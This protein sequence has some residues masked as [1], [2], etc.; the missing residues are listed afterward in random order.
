MST[1][2]LSQADLEN[3]PSSDTTLVQFN[4]R[5]LVPF[6]NMRF[7]SIECIY[8][9]PEP[10]RHMRNIFALVDSAASRPDAMQRYRELERGIR[11]ARTGAIEIDWADLRI[12]EYEE[13][14]VLKNELYQRIRSRWTYMRNSWHVSCGL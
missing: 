9:V 6:E 4:A 13:A 12:R 7:A 14:E 5:S 2:P 1:Q 8:Q 11:K 3:L 10:H